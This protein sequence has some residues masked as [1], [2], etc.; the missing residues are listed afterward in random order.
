MHWRV[1]TIGKILRRFVVVVGSKASRC[2][3]GIVHGSWIRSVWRHTEVCRPIDSV[4]VG[5]IRTL[6]LVRIEDEIAFFVL[7]WG[8]H[9]KVVIAVQDHFG[10][11]KV[12]LSLINMNIIAVVPR[13]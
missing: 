8:V 6:V 5:S 9:V 4:K 12:R 7:V 1:R 13:K 2:C 3:E 11:E 10:N